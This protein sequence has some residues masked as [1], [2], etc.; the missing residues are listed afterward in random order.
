ML[1]LRLEVSDGGRAMTSQRFFP[2]NIAAFA[3]FAF[4]LL[5][6]TG[7]AF[8]SS[9]EDAVEFI[10]T[11]DAGWEGMPFGGYTDVIALKDCKTSFAFAESFVRYDWNKVI[12]NSARIEQRGSSFLFRAGCKGECSCQGKCIPGGG[13]WIGFSVAPE[14]FQKALRVL[15]DACPGVETKF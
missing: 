3:S 2:T 11:G 8:A 9:A 14:R 15:I 12:W 4:V 10:L 1:G 7:S 13:L 6:A 5:L